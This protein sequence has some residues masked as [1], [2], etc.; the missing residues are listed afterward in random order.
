MNTQNVMNGFTPTATM[1]RIGGAV[2]I[3][4]TWSHETFTID[5]P[6]ETVCLFAD[7][8]PGQ[9]AARQAVMTIA[10]GEGFLSAALAE[11]SYSKTYVVAVMTPKL[12][13]GAEMGVRVMGR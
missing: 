5:Y 2:E 6:T 7:D 3:K 8:G 10:T 4:V 1:Q 11:D 12:I 9:A 13:R